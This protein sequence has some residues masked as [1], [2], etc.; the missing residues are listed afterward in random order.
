MD[1]RGPRQ[2]LGNLNLNVRGNHRWVVKGGN[3]HVNDPGNEGFVQID[4]ACSTCRAEMAVRL[5]VG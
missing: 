3:L 4:K 1:V 5:A 2:A